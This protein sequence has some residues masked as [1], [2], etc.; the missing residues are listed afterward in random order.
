MAKRGASYRIVLRTAKG[1]FAKP[2]T[3]ASYEIFYGKRRVIPRTAFPKSR[4][5]VAA[6]KDLLV[7]LISRIEKKR[8]KIVER[9]RREL[10]RRRLNEKRLR[11]HKEFIAREKRKLRTQRPG[12][13]LPKIEPVLVDKIG[14]QTLDFKDITTE[15]AQTLKNVSISDVLKTPFIPHELFFKEQI[16]KTIEISD[17]S[18]IY[19]SIMNLTL[20]E[21]EFIEINEQNFEYA[22]SEVFE[23]IYPHLVDY[24]EETHKSSTAYIL[25]LKFAYDPSEKSNW[26]DHGI[27]LGFAR[28]AMHTT[29]TLAQTLYSTYVRLTGDEVKLLKIGGKIKRRGA[30]DYLKDG[31]SIFIVG[32]TLESRLHDNDPNAN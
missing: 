6:K 29:K 16:D 31:A 5:T 11:E 12:V 21:D 7:L 26:V 15:A 13:R 9:R 20:P 17:G 28:I 14:R 2:R 24:W 32:A 19:L 1:G 18:K 27:S 30:R 4:K 23:K 25:R 8:L 10:R 3:A 22:F